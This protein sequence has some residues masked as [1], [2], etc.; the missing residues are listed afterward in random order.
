MAV[1]GDVVALQLLGEERVQ[2]PVQH[3]PVR[4]HLRHHLVGRHRGHVPREEKA[5]A[6]AIQLD[7]LLDT[8]LALGPEVVVSN[9][10]EDVLG[11]VHLLPRRPRA[12]LLILDLIPWRPRLLPSR[13]SHR[14]LA[15]TEMLLRIEV[16]VK[17]LAV[18]LKLQEELGLGGV[19]VRIDIPVAPGDPDKLPIQLGQELLHIKEVARQSVALGRVE[20]RPVLVMAPPGSKGVDQR[21]GVADQEG[22]QH[23]LVDLALEPEALRGVGRRRSIGRGACR[24]MRR[25]HGQ[26]ALVC[27]GIHESL[28]QRIVV[29]EQHDAGVGSL[30]VLLFLKKSFYVVGDQLYQAVALEEA[31]VGASHLDRGSDLPLGQDPVDLVVGVPQPR[32]DAV[33]DGGDDDARRGGAAIRPRVPDSIH[34]DASMR[35]LRSGRAR[36]ISRLREHPRPDRIRSRRSVPPAEGQRIPGQDVPVGEANDGQFRLEDLKGTLCLRIRPVAVVAVGVIPAVLRFR[37][38]RDEAEQDQARHVEGAEAAD[39]AFHRDDQ[40]DLGIAHPG[41]DGGM[42]IRR[43]AEI[44]THSSSP[45]AAKVAVAILCDAGDTR[46]QAH[47]TSRGLAPVR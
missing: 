35:R 36:G 26:L 21:V 42:R 3:F 15:Q 22:V 20:P 16:G 18:L 23:Q 6:V 44:A 9:E 46:C 13:C 39:Q 14:L 10:L 4:P 41:N 45:N 47:L 24:Q 1:V 7:K 29:P 40:R 33:S 38:R 34:P 31:L 19:D 28:P 30:L 8:T 43:V 17:G 37:V 5:R 32:E 2:V 12:G 11:E 25:Y 27:E